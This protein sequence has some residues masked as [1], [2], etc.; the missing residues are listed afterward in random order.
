MDNKEINILLVEDNPGDARLVAEMLRECGVPLFKITHAKRLDESL[1]FLSHGKYEVILLD[2]NL[3]DSHGL[4]GL[5][6]I[7]NQAPETPAIVLTGIKDDATGFA[8]LKS[9][10]ED[11]LVKGEINANSLSRSIR[12]AMERKSKESQLQ[13]LNRTLRALSNS[14]K[15]MVYAQ[16]E[17]AYLNEV[18]KIIAEDCGH[19]MVWI[20]FVEN[21]KNKTVRPVAQA[22][23]E[24]G[25]LKT[26]NI[27][28][29]DTERGRGPTGTAIRTG[30]PSICSNMLTDPNFKPWLR[31][32]TKRGYASSLVLPLVN[33][34][35]SF[36]AV[37]IYSKEANP[38]S[39]DE[40]QLLGEL[41][42]DLSYG[43]RAIRLKV[44]HQQ[45]EDSL[46]QTR[47]YLENLFNC[48][49]API[50]CWDI[51]FKI[52]RFNPAFEHLSDYKAEEVLGKNL[53]ILFPKGSRD[54]SLREIKRTLAGE[55]WEVVEIP[56]LRKDGRIRIALWNSA[57]VYAQDGETL[58]ATIAQGQDITERKKA[59]EELLKAHEELEEKVIERT[60]ELIK[61]N[62]QLSREIAERQNVEM[63]IRARN[64][65]LRLA[66][67][68]GSRKEYLDAVIKLFK[69][70][71]G[72]GCVGIRLL[73]EDGNIPYESYIGFSREFWEKENWLSV[74]EDKCACIRV[75][76][77]EFTSADAKVITPRG[78]FYCR[79]T[80]ELASFPR[81]GQEIQFRGRCI[82]EGFKSLTIIPIRFKEKIIGAIHFADKNKDL[83]EPKM[84]EHLESLAICVAED[85][86]KFNLSAKIVKSNELLERFF[87]ST[88]FHIAYMDID[89]NFIRVN[90]AY[91]QMVNRAPDFFVG[92]NHFTIYPD[93]ENEDIF[94]KVVETGKSY[95]TFD[96]PLVYK[97][98][99]ERGITYWDWSLQPLKDIS[100]KVEGLILFLVDT[101]KRKQAEEA[102]VKAQ[103]Q[104]VE[105]RR[106][107]DIGTLAATVA[108][109]L[110]NPLA[111]IQMASYNIKR[112]AQNPLLD[113]HLLTIENKV[114]E[115]E[116]IISNLLF[117]SRLRPPQHEN[118][119]ICESMN[120]CI[121]LV[122]RRFAQEKI[123]L[124][125]NLN[126]IKRVSIEAD[127]LQIKEVFCNILN[128]A[129]E[130]QTKENKRVEIK[131]EIED[132]SVKFIV[133]DSG[134]G[135][136]KND[137]ERIFDPF[138]TTKARGTGLGLTV[139]KQVINLH[140]G[141]I[142]IESEK[143]KGTVVSVRL[144]I[145]KE[146]AS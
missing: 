101:T 96:K 12:Y 126:S 33:N 32:A 135:I 26:L 110:R 3:P 141:S 1:G 23:L 127:P 82:R 73:N 50:V 116:Q 5:E 119:N 92:K 61:T 51:K 132:K 64:A 121:T 87:S 103:M 60:S 58:V 143:G 67:Q 105:A 59:E 109:E 52:T 16:N 55:Y 112:K 30:K 83:P 89:F 97:D 81:E 117:Y 107:S 13:R 123:N 25:Y 54:K 122:K 57:N 144:P 15:A 114:N 120:E 86:I 72:A 27:T 10:A 71:S 139:C 77:G 102:L 88:N 133:K 8:A 76:T 93:E 56:I 118:I 130:A 48:A 115:S 80:L 142:K 146:L 20:G 108:H 65:L 41:A 29:A 49:N 137:L 100:G 124:D 7:T 84:V 131:A 66:S 62:E 34:G 98:H 18:C 111:A 106:L 145:K 39:E 37:N 95:T 45:A 6:R 129:Y 31:E 21:D 99:P 2:M 22:G 42:D 19:T 28:W 4:N 69:F 136:D 43:I 63:E 125:V 53:S 44:E 40:V 94:K 75:I 113:K 138:F 35:K 90:Q 79:N 36:G 38:F 128:N 78:S 104:L 47:N 70:W 11:Y 140:G 46:R 74:K 24:S 91:S 68:V 17:Q 85:I 14:R 9:N 134:E